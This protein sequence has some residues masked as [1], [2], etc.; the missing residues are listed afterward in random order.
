MIVVCG[1]VLFSHQ[2]IEPRDA[3]GTAVD[4]VVKPEKSVIL[5][6]VKLPQAF[7][8]SFYVTFE[9]YVISFCFVVLV[10]V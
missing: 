2:W 10:S 7:L 5:K 1:Y 9:L 6:G 8:S 3:V 4:Y